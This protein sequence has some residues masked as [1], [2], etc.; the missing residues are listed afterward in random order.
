MGLTLEEIN[1]LRRIRDAARGNSAALPV[2][3][4]PAVA[5]DNDGDRKSVV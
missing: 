2:A 4:P 3:V 1:E 5:V